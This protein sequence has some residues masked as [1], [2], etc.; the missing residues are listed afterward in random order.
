MP[1]S[2]WLEL[3]GI[4]LLGAMSPGP[5]LAIVIRATLG[6]GRA[7]GM[8][9]A[10][11]HGVGVAVYATATVQGLMLVLATEPWLFRLLTW[12]GAAYLLWLG[13]QSLLAAGVHTVKFSTVLHSQSIWHSARAA[14]IVAL[15]NPHLAVFFLALFSQFVKPGMS[16]MDKFIMVLTACTLDII[17]FTLLAYG[18]SFPAILGSLQQHMRLINRV[19]G[20]VLLLLCVRVLTL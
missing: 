18:L 3:V 15:S 19:S 12:G 1:L 6:N 2:S 16:S 7:H 11:A 13:L 9:A 14:L 20:G 10:L 5:S 4:C 8:A 17:W